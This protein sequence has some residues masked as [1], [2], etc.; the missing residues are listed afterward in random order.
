MTGVQSCALPI[1]LTKPS[2]PE[3]EG[4]WK[5]AMRY[6]GVLMSKVAS[7]AN[8]RYLIVDGG[9]GFRVGAKVFELNVGFDFPLSMLSLYRTKAYPILPFPTGPLLK[10]WWTLWKSLKTPIASLNCRSLMERAEA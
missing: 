7:T 3:L 9:K 10:A 2:V 1:S 6:L 4:A 8:K 5:R